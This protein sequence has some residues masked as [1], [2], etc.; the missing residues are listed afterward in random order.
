MKTSTLKVIL[1]ILIDLVCLSAIVVL[2]L[3]MA[4]CLDKDT[5][6]KK[7]IKPEL[8]NTNE[9]VYDYS[10]IIDKNTGVVYLQVE[11]GYKIGITAYLKPDGT[12]YLADELGLP[13]E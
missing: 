12:P 2:V 11:A 8:V 13:I 9:N 6:E 5:D 4:G 1:D 7:V 10:Y 3:F